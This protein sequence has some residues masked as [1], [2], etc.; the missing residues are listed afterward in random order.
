M[1]PVPSCAC[2]QCTQ[3]FVCIRSLHTH[4]V[5]I[6]RVPNVQCSCRSWVMEDCLP[7]KNVSGFCGNHCWYGE[8]EDILYCGKYSGYVAPTSGG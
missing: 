8:Q 5:F 3:G 7:D 1:L 2:I 6:M 4:E